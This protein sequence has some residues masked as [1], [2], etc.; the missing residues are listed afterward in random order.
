MA[1]LTTGEARYKSLRIKEYINGEDS[2]QEHLFHL[3]DAF[4]LNGV[5]FSGI[6][7]DVIKKMT[8]LEFEARKEAFLMYVEKE[9]KGFNSVADIVTPEPHNCPVMTPIS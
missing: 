2:G 9:V 4:T 1:L 3:A 5:D 7:E 8:P 6:S